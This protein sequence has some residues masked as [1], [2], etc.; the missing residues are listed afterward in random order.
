MNRNL[1]ILARLSARNYCVKPP[2][3]KNWPRPMMLGPQTTRHPKFPGWSLY[4][5]PATDHKYLWFIIMSLFHF[6]GFTI[7]LLG[8]C[9][10][11]RTMYG[12]NYI[13][14][15]LMMHALLSLDE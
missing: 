11:L 2:G 14:Y 9:K 12:N 1:L 5:L 8:V 15:N 13:C 3:R 7:P 6:T 4:Y 10:M